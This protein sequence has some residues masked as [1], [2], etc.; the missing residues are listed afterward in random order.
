MEKCI[1]T[2]I[3]PLI[4]EGGSI[5]SGIIAPAVSEFLAGTKTAEKA[6]ND[7]V[8]EVDR[9]MRDGGYY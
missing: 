8:K 2:P 7:A 6:L 1:P 3:V 5:V 9:L 4:P